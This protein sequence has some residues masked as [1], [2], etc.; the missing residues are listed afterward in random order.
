MVL[1]FSSQVLQFPKALCEPR[2]TCRRPG[3]PKHKPLCSGPLQVNPPFRA[4]RCLWE[5]RRPWAPAPL[6]ATEE[7]IIYLLSSF[8]VLPS[9]CS[10]PQELLYRE[11]VFDTTFYWEKMESYVGHGHLGARPQWDQPVHVSTS[12]RVHTQHC[13]TPHS[14][15]AAWLTEGTQLGQF[16]SCR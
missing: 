6:V 10:W 11:I 9:L 15:P 1:G 3:H 8:I 7:G 16:R 13:Q 2:G 14:S 5:Q 12:V 4:I